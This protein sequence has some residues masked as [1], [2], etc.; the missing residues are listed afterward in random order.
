MPS[1][2]NMPASMPEIPPENI[3]AAYINIG[4]KIYTELRIL[5]AQINHLLMLKDPQLTEIDIYYTKLAQEVYDQ[6]W[7]SLLAKLGE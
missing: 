6:E 1:E 7:V 4:L 3:P 5:R 2:I